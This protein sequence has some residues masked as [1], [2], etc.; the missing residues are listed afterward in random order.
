M[1]TKLRL[2]DEVPVVRDEM[3]LINYDGSRRF[4]PYGEPEWAWWVEV[5]PD[6]SELPGLWEY[7]EEEGVA[8]CM[9]G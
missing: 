3:N 8:A 2:G 9:C 7:W 5:S 6:G 1:W 4:V